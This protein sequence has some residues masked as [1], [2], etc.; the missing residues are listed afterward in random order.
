MGRGRDIP[1][2]TLF[3]PTFP[4]SAGEFVSAL[5]LEVY[6]KDLPTLAKLPGLLE[7]EM[8]LLDGLVKSVWPAGKQ[9]DLTNIEPMQARNNLLSPWMHGRV[10]GRSRSKYLLRGVSKTATH[11]ESGYK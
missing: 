7:I 8:A 1:L 9:V 3:Q 2:R 10:L 6:W 5:N 11:L 4:A